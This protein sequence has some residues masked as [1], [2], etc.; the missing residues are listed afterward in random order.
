M[1]L[2]D[3]VHGRGEVVALHWQEVD[4]YFNRKI[5][6]EEEDED[7]VDL[8]QGQSAASAACDSQDDPQ[9]QAVR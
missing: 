9:G 5:A 1:R 6:Q 3:D 8:D 2:H 4:A 7:C